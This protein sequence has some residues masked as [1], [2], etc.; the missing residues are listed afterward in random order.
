ARTRGLR[1]RRDRDRFLERTGHRS[2]EGAVGRLRAGVHDDAARV[3][4]ASICGDRPR[5]VDRQQGI[6]ARSQSGWLELPRSQLTRSTWTER[7]PCTPYT[8]VISMS[9]VR[10]GPVT[11]TGADDMTA[12][13]VRCPITFYRPATMCPYG[14]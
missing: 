2:R 1:G 9:E 10:E 7:G 5:T 8:V 11:S 12:S 4:G 6:A 3:R 14:E 13:A